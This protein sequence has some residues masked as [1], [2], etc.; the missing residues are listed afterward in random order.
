MQI[1]KNK[2]KL[3]ALALALGCVALV[4]PTR[5]FADEDRMKRTFSNGVVEI[6]EGIFTVTPGSAI[7]NFAAPTSMLYLRGQDNFDVGTLDALQAAETQRDAAEENAQNEN[8]NASN[9]TF[10]ASPYYSSFRGKTRDTSVYVDSDNF[11]MKRT[12][13]IGGV[14]KNFTAR[15]K[16][17]VFLGYARA[18][19]S[20]DYSV[21]NEDGV[22]QDPD[23]CT[24]CNCTACLNCTCTGE[25]DRREA[26]IRVRNHNFSPKI[27]AVDFQFGGSFTHT[28]AN[29]WVVSTNVVAGAQNYAWSRTASVDICVDGNKSDP[30]VLYQGG[31]TGNTLSINVELSKGY[32]MNEAWTFTP[33]FGIES[34]HS[35][36]W[37][38]GESGP[39][40]P[41]EVRKWVGNN[42]DWS[43]WGLE[44]SVTL[45]R[46]TARV[47]TSLAYADDN[48]GF[49]GKVFYGTRLGDQVKYAASSDGTTFANSGSN[50]GYGNDSLKL[51]GGLWMALN[52]EKTMTLGGAYDATLYNRATSQTAS[53]TFTTRF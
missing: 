17:G 35:W 5:L 46:T 40:M 22:K 19:M 10:W 33:A 41:D 45:S 13:F 50:I 53:G 30:K 12:G 23:N 27:D 48:W 38:G 24:V 49:N 37:K 47:G 36:I 8:G 20:Q 43:A 34:A 4:N 32:K 26:K 44:D 14:E 9:K 1:V 31:T 21:E 7:G 18:G 15:T 29:E 3:T 6:S 39:D 42:S 16:A 2:G 52:E 25:D 11:I 51:G 28:F